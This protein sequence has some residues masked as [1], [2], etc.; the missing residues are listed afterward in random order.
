MCS[1]VG[2]A[3][4]RI[5]AGDGDSDVQVAAVQHARR[6]DMNADGSSTSPGVSTCQP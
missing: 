5:A 6:L 1:R 4:S 2:V 3:S